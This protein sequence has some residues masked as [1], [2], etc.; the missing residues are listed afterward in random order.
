M[1]KICMFLGIILILICSA[2]QANEMRSIDMNVFIDENGNANVTETWQYYSDSGTECYHSYK[3]L[4]NS[5]IHEFE[6]L[7]IQQFRNLG[8]WKIRNLNDRRFISYLV[9]L[10][11]DYKNS[12]MV[13][14]EMLY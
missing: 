14:M 8:I 6:D 10:S 1:Q 11:H 5:G 3:N 12:T 2:V 9:V 13:H 4:G 7:E